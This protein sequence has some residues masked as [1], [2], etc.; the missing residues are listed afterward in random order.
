MN[1]TKVKP[2]LHR[3]DEY[4][5]THAK[6]SV[7]VLVHVCSL[8]WKLK[9]RQMMEKTMP[10][11]ERIISRT[12]RAT[13]TDNTSSFTLDPSYGIPT[14]TRHIIYWY[15]HVLSVMVCSEKGEQ[16]WR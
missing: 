13:C 6:D 8:K 3:V 11:Q 5:Y 12:V 10:T 9:M 14:V 1:I 16:Q 15:Y 7:K 4:N 2:V